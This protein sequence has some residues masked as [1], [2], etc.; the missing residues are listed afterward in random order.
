MPSDLKGMKIHCWPVH[1]CAIEGFGAVPVTLPNQELYTALERGTVDASTAL[2]SMTWGAKYYEVL[3]S[4]V[5]FDLG[6][7]VTAVRIN[8]KTFEGLL[9]IYKKS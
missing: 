2:W 3:K 8:T 6:T 1:M 5:N 9:P 7:P 4:H